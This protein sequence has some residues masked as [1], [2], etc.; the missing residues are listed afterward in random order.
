MASTLDASQKIDV[1]AARLSDPKIG[2]L[3]ALQDADGIFRL[4]SIP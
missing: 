1:Y 4:T 2:M 3:Q